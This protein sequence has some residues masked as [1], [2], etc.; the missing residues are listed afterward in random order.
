MSH[1]VRESGLSVHHRCRCNLSASS[2][3]AAMLILL[4]LP[5]AKTVFGIGNRS[6]KAT[7][8]TAARARTALRGSRPG[9]LLPAVIADGRSAALLCG[10]AVAQGKH[11]LK[12]KYPGRMR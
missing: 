7:W 5:P 3:S 8:E 6:S 2:L 4:P 9:L 10:A 12:T 1:G 11:A